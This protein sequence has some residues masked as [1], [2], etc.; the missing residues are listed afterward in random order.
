M[1]VPLMLSLTQAAKQDMLPLHGDRGLPATVYS[2]PALHAIFK[3]I[4]F[5]SLAS[6]RFRALNQTLSLALPL[7]GLRC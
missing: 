3:L 5:P 1:L 6:W 2:R 7:S 4:E